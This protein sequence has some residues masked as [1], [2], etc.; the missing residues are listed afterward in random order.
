[1]STQSHSTQ[2]SFTKTFPVFLN[3]INIKKIYNK[4]EMIYFKILFYK[5]L[6]ITRSNNEVLQKN[7][8]NIDGKMF[9]KI[10]RLIVKKFNNYVDCKHLSYQFVL[11]T[12]LDLLTIRKLNNLTNIYFTDMNIS[13]AKKNKNILLNTFKN[14]FTDIPN[15]TIGLALFTL[16]RFQYFSKKETV[17]FELFS[18]LIYDS[19]LHYIDN[20]DMFSVATATYKRFLMEK[21]ITKRLGY[22]GR[23]VIIN[24]NSE[25]MYMLEPPKKNEFRTQLMLENDPTYSLPLLCHYFSHKSWY[26]FFLIDYQDVNPDDF[27]KFNITW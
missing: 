19:H 20:K 25:V 18:I 9:K 24:E 14:K 21:C 3:N 13:L 12:F 10:L 23:K 15:T 2:I 6:Y 16:F 7:N 1:M 27:Y 17:P 4:E 5:F 26:D 22:I 11:S 8:L